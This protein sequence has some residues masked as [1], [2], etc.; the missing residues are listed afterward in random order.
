[1]TSKSVVNN[2]QEFLLITVPSIYSTVINIFLEGLDNKIDGIKRI[3]L[4]SLEPTIITEEFLL[5]LKN[6]KDFAPHFHLSLQSG[7]TNTLK[8][9]NRHYTVEEFGEKL[10]KLKEKLPSVSITTDVITGFPNETEEE[11]KQDIPSSFIEINLASNGRIDGIPK[12]LHFRDY[13]ASDALDLNVDDDDK[14]VETKIEK[15]PENIVKVDIEIPAKDAVDY[16]NNAAKRLAQY[17]N[18]PGFRKGKAPMAIVEKHY[19]PEVFYEDTF[20]EIV[21]EEYERELNRKKVTNG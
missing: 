10:A 8:R 2:F 15:L 14:L 11:L 19:G 9:M 17:V 20:N 4:G 7:C 5:A 12:K 6:L 18:I 21:P 13:S 3:R 1:M 16:Y